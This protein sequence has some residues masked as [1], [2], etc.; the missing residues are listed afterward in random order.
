MLCVGVVESVSSLPGA[1]RGPAL[2]WRWLWC[3]LVTRDLFIGYVLGAPWMGAGCGGGLWGRPWVGRLWGRKLWG[4]AA[5]GRAG[6]GGA[7]A[8]SVAL[9]S[10]EWCLSRQVS[11]SSQ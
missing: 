10:I 9:A 7:R 4:G 11:E 1:G 3:T 8:N 6:R 2:S 5:Q